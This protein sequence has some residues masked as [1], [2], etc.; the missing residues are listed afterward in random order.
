MTTRRWY[1][2]IPANGTP[3]GL[4]HAI[5]RHNLDRLPGEKNVYAGRHRARRRPDALLRDSRAWRW[6]IRR[7][8]PFPI[9]H[10]STPARR[11]RCGAR[12]VE[13]VSSGDLVQRFEAG[14]TSGQLVQHRRASEALYRIKDRAFDV[15]AGRWGRPA[16]DGIRPS[17]ADGRMVRR[18]RA[19]SDSDRSWR[20]AQR[21]E[22]ALPSGVVG[23]STIAADE[24]LLLDLW[25]KLDEQGAVFADITWVGFAGSAYHRRFSGR[26]GRWPR[27]RR[28]G[29]ARPGCGGGQRDVR[30][31]EAD[32]AA[33]EILERPDTAPDPPPDGPQPWRT[34]PRQWRSPG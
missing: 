20:S 26:S 18:G 9:S 13:I 19:V 2:L 29:A 6:N 3:R 30:G 16:A 27:T 4:V 5:E 15:A 22:P 10:G 28:R 17:A 34:G 21:R 23:S 25:G 1:Y 8:A 14:W 32:R 7:I 31:W 24:V 11:K 12:G 33:R